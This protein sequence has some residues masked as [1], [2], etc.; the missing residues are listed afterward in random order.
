MTMILTT[1]VAMTS[2]LIYFIVLIQSSVT[3]IPQAKWNTQY[4]KPEL[5]CKIFNKSCISSTYPIPAD[6]IQLAAFSR[7]SKDRVGIVS[8]RTQQGCVDGFL[9][10]FLA[11]GV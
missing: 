5:L 1:M 9:N 6:S 10:T 4:V 3:V 8:C 11:K 2:R 7:R